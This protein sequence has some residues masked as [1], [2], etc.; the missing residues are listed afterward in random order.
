MEKQFLTRREAAAFV[1]GKGLPCAPAT[2]AKLATIGGGPSF[3]KFGR[4][5]VY[6]PGELD[7]WIGGSKSLGP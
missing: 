6:M 7:A 4:N 3:R 5:V 1:R 2:L